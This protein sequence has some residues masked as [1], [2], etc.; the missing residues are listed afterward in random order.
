MSSS[1]FSSVP[2]SPATASEFQTTF[3]IVGS[4]QI[5]T[6]RVASSRAVTRSSRER[7]DPSAMR[8]PATGTPAL[9][10][11]RRTTSA[12]AAVVPWPTACKPIAFSTISAVKLSL[13]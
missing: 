5:S 12:P 11:S 1:L 8:T 13:Q 4:F 3:R 2:G 6:S 10:R 7:P 9:R